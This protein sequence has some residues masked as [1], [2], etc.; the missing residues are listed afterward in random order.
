MPGDV[1][2]YPAYARVTPLGASPFTWTRSTTDVRALQRATGTERL[3]ATWYGAPTFSFEVNLTDGRVHQVALYALDWDSDTRIQ[4]VEVRN[5]ATGALL[6]SRTMTRFQNG[7]YL[8]WRLTGRVTIHVTRT[9][10]AN[11]VVSGLFFS[12]P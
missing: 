8:V 2:Q 10:G 4:R 6:D 5:A 1:I 7:Q 11:G 3:A 12:T 9:A